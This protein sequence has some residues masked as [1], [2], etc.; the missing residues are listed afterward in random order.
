MSHFPTCPNCGI[1]SDHH[2]LGCSFGLMVAPPLNWRAIRC[3][4]VEWDCV[5]GFNG[6]TRSNLYRMCGPTFG[7]WPD[8]TLGDVADMGERRWRIDV[9]NAGPKTVELIKLIIDYA[10]AGRDVTRPKDAYE[11]RPL[12]DGAQ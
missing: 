3:A 4:D 12:K 10:A 2:Q 6:H 11:P 8:K 5:P 1:A 7:K 9:E